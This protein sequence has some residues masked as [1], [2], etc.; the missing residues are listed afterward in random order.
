MVARRASGRFGIVF[1]AG[2]SIHRF[3]KPT[4]HLMFAPPWLM[5]R[6]AA[7]SPSHWETPWHR[8]RHAAPASKSNVI[9]RRFS[10][11]KQLRRAAT[12]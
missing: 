4:D 3:L 6:P 5:P 12:R 1:P 9:L 10:K 7:G 2:S 11:L 8:A